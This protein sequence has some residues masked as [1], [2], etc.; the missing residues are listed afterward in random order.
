M[1]RKELLA[2]AYLQGFTAEHTGK[3]AVA[4]VKNAGSVTS[5]LGSVH[6]VIREASGSKQVDSR[7][8]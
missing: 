7:K 4:S 8:E 5:G 3:K 2:R 1:E 6:S